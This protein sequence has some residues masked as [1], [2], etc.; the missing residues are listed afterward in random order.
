MGLKEIYRIALA[1]G[2]TAKQAGAEFNVR[3]DSLHK[4]GSKHG[5]PKLISEIEYANRKNIEHLTDADLGR[6][7]DKL[8]DNNMSSSDEYRYCQDE[9]KKREQ[10]AKK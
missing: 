10:N 8:I 2:L 7:A 5:L 6:Y 4:V 9:L 3:W 1:R